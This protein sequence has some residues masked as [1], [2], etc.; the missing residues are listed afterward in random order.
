ML[1][2]KQFITFLKVFCSIPYCSK[3]ECLSSSQ[4]F[5]GEGKITY[6]FSTNANIL[7]AN[8]PFS[9]LPAGGE[10]VGFSTLAE[11]YRECIRCFTPPQYLVVLTFKVYT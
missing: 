2:F 7:S 8:F 9:V 5:G 3:L 1:V 6:T 11:H 10:G 4:I